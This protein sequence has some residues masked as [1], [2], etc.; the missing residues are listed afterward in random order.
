MGQAPPG[1]PSLDAL[2]PAD[3]DVAA[4]CQPSTDNATG[5]TG[6]LAHDDCTEP[7]SSTLP[8]ALVFGYQMRDDASF[9]TSWDA[10]NAFLNFD[11]TDP[12][13]DNSCPTS[14]SHGGA[15]T[16]D[17]GGPTIGKIECFKSAKGTD[18]Y[19][20][21]ETNNRTILCVAGTPDQSRADVDTWW[22]DDSAG[23]NE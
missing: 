22:N 4:D 15:T 14:S 6:V 17:D 21:S 1:I 12:G 8:G 5:T 10:M 9:N 7:D 11:P 2:L 20:W 19:L 23:R 18:V 3:L 13:V 16:W